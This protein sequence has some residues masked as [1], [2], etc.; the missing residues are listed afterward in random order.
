MCYF[1]YY[2]TL[3]ATAKILAINLR[4]VS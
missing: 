2:F 1:G 4:C 3:A